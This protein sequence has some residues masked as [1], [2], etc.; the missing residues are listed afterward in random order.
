M[1]RILTTTMLATMMALGLA[2]GAA[3]A[4]ERSSCT[5][6]KKCHGPFFHKRCESVKVC[7]DRHFDHRDWKTEHW[8]HR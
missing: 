2:S 1:T 4:H 5:W 7:S 6:V 8:R 3:N